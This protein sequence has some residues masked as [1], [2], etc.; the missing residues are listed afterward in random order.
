[1]STFSDSVELSGS[2]GVSSTDD[3]IIHTVYH[4]L[5]AREGHSLAHR[6]SRFDAFCILNSKY[7]LLEH[8]T[9]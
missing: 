2:A 6:A 8:A 1:M 5:M 4:Q 7:G 9:A 3:T